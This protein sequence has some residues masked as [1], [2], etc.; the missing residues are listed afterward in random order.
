MV[1]QV[2][3]TDT[4]KSKELETSQSKI[5]NLPLMKFKL[6]SNYQ[7]I[8]DQPSAIKQLVEGISAR[9]YYQTLLEVTGSG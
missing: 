1:L 8:G 5:V 9:E 4:Q 3:K 6:I 2:N 7:S